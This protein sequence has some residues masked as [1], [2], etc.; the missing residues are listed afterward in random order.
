[1]PRMAGSDVGV[2]WAVEKPIKKGEKNGLYYNER[3]P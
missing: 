1:V 2:I 3:T